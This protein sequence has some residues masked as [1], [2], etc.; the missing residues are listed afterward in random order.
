MAATG[1]FSSWDAEE[2]KSRRMAS[3]RLVSV[4]SEMASKTR[5]SWG[6]ELAAA[7]RILVG[8]P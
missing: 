3:T 2:T 1:V 6:K 8:L 7:C 4:M 5:R